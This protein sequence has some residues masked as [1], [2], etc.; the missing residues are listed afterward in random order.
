VRDRGGLCVKNG[1]L[2][3]ALPN[4]LLLLLPPHGS[5]FRNTDIGD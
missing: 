3:L 5:L 2:E 4:V 1:V